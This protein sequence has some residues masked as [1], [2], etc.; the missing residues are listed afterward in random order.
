MRAFNRRCVLHCRSI[1][2][3]RDLKQF[4]GITFKITPD[5]TNSTVLLSCLGVGYMNMN[6]KIA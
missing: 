2:L 4:F 1:Q 3:L 6:K 5:P